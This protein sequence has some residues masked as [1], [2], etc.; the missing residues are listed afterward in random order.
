MQFELTRYLSDNWVPVI[1][2]DVDGPSSLPL[3]LD[4]EV[5]NLGKFAASRRVARTIYLGSAPLTQ[6]A[7]RGLEDRR[8]KLGCV[9]PSESPAVFGDAL[10]RLAGAATYLYQDG[11]RYWY[12]T[13]PTVTKLADDRA[14]QLKRD[15]DKVV[16]ELDLPLRKNLELRADFSRIHPMPQSG[17]DVPD[18]LDA[19]LVVLGV[20]HPYSKE[21]YC[22][23]ET[24]AKAIFEARG[25]APRLYRNTLVF[26]AADKTRLQDLDEA[27]RRYLAWESILAE[28][29]TLN[30]DPQ[31]VKQAETQKTAADGAV[32]ARIPETY[33]WLLVPMQATP[34]AAIEW[35]ATR[36]S[37]QDALAVRASKKLRSDELLLTGFA[38]TRLRM[39]LDRVPLWR[40]DHVP[41][42]QLIEDFARY[43][44]LP[45]LKDSPVLFQS[46]SDGLALLTWE[47]DS[48]AFA[49]SFDDSSERYRGLRCGQMVTVSSE[50][51]TGVLVKPGAARKQFDAETL[52]TPASP[53]SAAGTAGTLAEGPTSGTG[54]PASGAPTGSPSTPSK[55]K[56]FYGTVALDATRVGRDAG[57][58]ADEVIAHLS[59]LVGSSVKVTLE[60]EANVPGGVPENIVRTVTENKRG[61]K[62][63]GGPGRAPD[64]GPELA[65][66]EILIDY[67]RLAVGLPRPTS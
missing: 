34:Q 43:L 66:I 42:K 13:Q 63:V 57:R 61:A 51:L 7:H 52:V 28:K 17:Q 18:D 47:K 48:F 14:E 5:P 31:Q 64:V 30:L 49:E 2:K 54:V 27:T 26:L 21:P 55:P 40:G 41:I 24:A 46:I 32:A 39:E 10:R 60:I 29:V 3:R 65:L 19:R 4:G 20:D 33:Q 53:T 37:G 8:V 6:A 11:P 35:Q 12:S 36:L 9:M 22:P 56:R 67:A 50:N 44:Y 62:T 59:G 23:A 25:T 16:H 45:R 58:I 15:P 1:E 38:A